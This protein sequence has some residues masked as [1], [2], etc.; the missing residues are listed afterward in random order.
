MSFFVAKVKNVL[1]GDTLVLVPTKTAQFPAPERTLT[2]SYVR[3][4]D[5]FEAKEFLRD[6]LIGKEIKFKVNYKNPT[7]N[8][9]FGDVQAPI[10]KSL[11]QYLLEK[12]LVKLKDNFNE[13]EGDIYYDLKE[14]ENGAKLKNVGV[15]STG[16]SSSIETID[17]LSENVIQKSQKYPLKVIVE[18]VISGDRIVGRVIVNPK[19]HFQSP[20]LLAGIKTP[21]TDDIN[22]PAA[23]TKVAQQAKVFVEEKLLTTKAELT[24]SIIGESQQGLPIAIIHHP[25]GNDI[26]EKSLELGYG[27]IVDWQS[28][29]VGATTMVKYR[30]AEQIAKALGKGLYASTTSSTPKTTI[31]S[32]VKSLKPGITVDNVSIAKIVSADTIVVRLQNDDEITVQL[33]SIRSPKPNDTTIAGDS[34][35]KQALVSSA[36]EFVRSKVIGK[37]GS[38]YIDGIRQENK[39]LGFD[40][41][42]LVS[43]KFG[44]TDLSELIVENGWATV[45]KHNKAT[46]HERSHNWD[47]LIEIEENQKKLAKNG[48]FSTNLDKVITVSNRIIDASENATKAKTFFNGF[49]QKGRISG[50]YYIEFI[51]SINRVKLFNPKEGTK[52]T[53]ILGGLTNEKSQVLND[54]GVK[55]LN[56]RFLQRGGI[57]FE[58]YDLDKLG[59]FIGNLY[60]N[61]NSLVPIQVSLLELGLI[62]IHDLAVNSNPFSNDL[63]KAEEEAKSTKKGIWSNYDEAKELALL[64]NQVSQ[65]KIDIKPQFF[66]IEAVDIDKESGIISFHYL[67]TATVKKFSEFKTSFNQFHTQAPSASQSSIDLPFNLTRVPKKNDLVSAKFS[68]NG[69]YYRARVLSHDKSNGKFEVKHLDFGNIDKVSLSSLRILPQKFNL[70]NYPVFSHTT[71][72]Q[73]IRLPPSKPT[74]Y[75]TDAIYALEDLV[76]D[77]KLVISALPGNGTTSEYE[78][79]LYDAEQ[80][81]KDPDY[82]INKQLV[83]DG[84]G[85]VDTKKVKD[86]VKDYVTSLV[87]VQSKAKSQHLGCW[88]FGD[89]SF[90]DE[91]NAF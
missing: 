69:K 34:L 9:E 75:L 15:W 16:E 76:F 57:E 45:I 82:T 72:L 23:T 24:I 86:S 61:T 51:P 8:R 18:R 83:Q 67:D 52:L 55:Y 59:S 25:S 78:G 85:I 10:F 54:K 62:K 31:V 40:S 3:A 44:S 46:S 26:I 20:I 19:Q 22:Q 7:T 58:I 17:K 80:S 56:K 91:D 29:L 70:I 68:E 63:I 5:T 27:E 37:S 12:G 32:P 35:K 77:K 21:R 11:I 73:N 66:D 43:F 84:W 48:L 90:D 36:R 88:E 41:R 2:L 60:I 30:K 6:L 13:N 50:G 38:L 74:D 81:L 87:T 65:V 39:E 71:T 14:V 79:I 53:L 33:A 42:F 64:E 47:K 1:S 4:A 28:T 89:V 49:K